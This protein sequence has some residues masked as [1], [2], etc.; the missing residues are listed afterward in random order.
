MLGS[1][2]NFPVILCSLFVSDQ[3]YSY[4]NWYKFYSYA[5]F[6]WKLSVT[7]F[8]LESK[9]YNLSPWKSNKLI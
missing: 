8:F 2:K 7:H 4:P 5:F 3:E 6:F 9:I 1:Q